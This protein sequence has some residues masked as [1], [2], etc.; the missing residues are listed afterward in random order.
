MSDR[1][2]ILKMLGAICIALFVF[3][4]CIMLVGYQPFDGKHVGTM[5][6]VAVVGIVF[7]VVAKRSKS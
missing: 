4:T 5:V 1:T 6:F 3:G 2:K 7:L